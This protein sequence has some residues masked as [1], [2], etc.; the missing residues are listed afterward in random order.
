M[1]IQGEYKFKIFKDGD[2][3]IAKGTTP[4]GNGIMI[5]QGRENDIFY[6]I[7]DAYTAINEIKISWWKRLL[8]KL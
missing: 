5:T 3:Y 1:N 8:A 2:F 4:D 7:G 6:M